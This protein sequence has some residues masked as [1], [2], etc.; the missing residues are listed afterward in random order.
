MAA[1]LHPT[2]PVVDA[3]TRAL[4]LLGE[5]T[6]EYAAVRELRDSYTEPDWP[7]HVRTML[8]DDRTV[9]AAERGTDDG[10]ALREPLY[11]PHDHS[12]E[13]AAYQV[14][15]MEAATDRVYSTLR[16]EA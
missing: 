7:E 9:W 3:L 13:A 5:G 6:P 8:P 12:D 1:I 16:C 4:S 2:N 15:W 11:T 14:A 10:W